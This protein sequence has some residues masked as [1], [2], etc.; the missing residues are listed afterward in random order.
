MKLVHDIKVYD[1]KLT[2]IIKFAL[3]LKFLPFVL[4]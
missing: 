2:I 3:Y 4:N 1:D